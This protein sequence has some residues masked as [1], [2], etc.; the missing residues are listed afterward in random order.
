MIACEEFAPTL[1]NVAILTSLSMFGEVQVA[2]LSVSTEENKKRIEALTS[3]L[4][5]IKYSTNKSMYL[6]WATFRGGHGL[7]SPYKL[8]V[9]LAYWLN[10][11]MFRNPSEDG[12]NSFISNGDTLA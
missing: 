5:K 7:N 10:Y 4:S 1:E 3:F 6:S 11:F 8:D 2:D 12:M 9:F